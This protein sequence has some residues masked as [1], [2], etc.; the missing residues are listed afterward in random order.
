MRQIDI[1]S[2]FFVTSP[3][4]ALPISI[5]EMKHALR[6]DTVDAAGDAEIE[7]IIGSATKQ[8]ENETS[9]RLVIATEQLKLDRFPDVIELRRSPIHS[10]LSIKY[11]DINDAEQTLSSTKY[12]VDSRSLTGRIVPV[13]GEI[14]PSTYETLDAVTVEF[15]AGH[16]VPYTAVNATNVLTFKGALFSNTDLVRVTNTGGAVPGGLAIRTD[17]YVV[18]VSGSTGKL[19]TSVGGG[20]IDLTD[21][22]TETNFIGEVPPSAKNILKLIGQQEFHGY[23]EKVQDAI[24]SLMWGFRRGP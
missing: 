1:G 8:F 23:D 16:A 6:L 13:F 21:D 12:E 7:A 19:E 10:V 5:T 15:T 18:N 20:A 9:V 4:Q 17:Y 14:W 3:A 2:S 22:G 11:Q 24:N